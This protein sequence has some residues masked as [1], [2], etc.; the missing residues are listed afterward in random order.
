MSI[1]HIQRDPD[2]FQNPTEFRPERFQDKEEL[3]RMNPYAFIPFSAGPRNCIGKKVGE[4]EV[5]IVLTHIL[6]NMWVEA[7]IPFE[8]TRPYP[9][10]VLFPG[11]GLP[12]KV[13]RR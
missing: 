10:A 13:C 7:M 1:Y 3:S 6:R 9:A 5:K 8:E 12:V 11:A 4:L 2:Y